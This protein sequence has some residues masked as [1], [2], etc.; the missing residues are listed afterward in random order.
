[1]APAPPP[2]AAPGHEPPPA[3]EPPPE[4]PLAHEPPPAPE[5]PPAHEPPPATSGPLTLDGFTE[6]WPAVLD[7]VK[8]ENQL[9]GVALSEA[10]PVALAGS[11]VAIA[12]APGDAFNQRMAEGPA[13]KA[14]LEEAIRALCGTRL[15]AGFEL[16]ELEDA[17]AEQP[18]LSG[19]D[20]VAH[21]VREFDAEEIVPAPD[22]EGEGA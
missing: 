6:L 18:P 5:P 21:I 4:P 12:F 2:A 22:S 11:E 8:S 15:R 13:N 20:L 10:R 9:L 1:V 16:R 19:E 17:P 7:A 14:V 3:H